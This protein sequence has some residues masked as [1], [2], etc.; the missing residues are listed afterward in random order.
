MNFSEKF[1]QN[2][3]ASQ[4]SLMNN[5]RNLQRA[6]LFETLKSKA[7]RGLGERSS[8]K[9]PKKLHFFGH[10]GTER[11]TASFCSRKGQ[12]QLLLHAIAVGFSLIVILLIVTVMNSIVEDH[13]E[14]VG[15]KEILQSCDIMK[16]SVEKIMLQQEYTSPTNT[17]LGRIFVAMPERIGGAGYRTRFANDSLIIE[18]FGSP[19]LNDT[20]IL[21]FN[22]SFKGS[23]KGGTTRITLTR[24]ANGTDEIT[25]STV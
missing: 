2:D 8:P 15:K 4:S 18:T 7:F 9:T 16:T 24:Y 19:L 12:S 10:E 14:F 5:M 1:N 11:E 6:K 17:T 22:A 23:T 20:C 3:R 13:Q 25:V 21:G